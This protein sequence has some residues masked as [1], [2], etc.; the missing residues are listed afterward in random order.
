MSTRSRVAVKVSYNSVTVG[1]RDI[2]AGQIIHAYVH[3]DGYPFNMMPILT[4]HYDTEEKVIELISHGDMS[5]LAES[6]EKPEGH[7]FDNKIK[8]YTVYYGR[9]RG[10]EGTEFALGNWNEAKNEEEYGYFFEDGKWTWTC[11]YY[12]NLKELEEDTEA[13]LYKDSFVEQS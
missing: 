11:S 9:D 5:S 2:E 8:G 12:K 6:C 3:Y 1:G 4:K 13:M 7:S 10:E